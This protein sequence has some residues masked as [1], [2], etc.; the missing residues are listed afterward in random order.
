MSAKRQK[1]QWRNRIV[2]EGTQAAAQ[3]LAHPLNARRHPAAQ[4]DALRGVLSEVGWVQRVIVN[5]TTGH[6]LDG[7]ARIEEALS[8]D[9]SEPVPFVEVEVSEAEERLILA[10]LDPVS[11]MATYDKE[12]LDTLLREVSTGDAAVRE[13]LSNLAKDSGLY[14]EGERGEG[15][16][17]SFNFTIK[18]DDVNELVRLQKMLGV[19]SPSIRCDE[20]MRQMA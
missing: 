12:V 7:H 14:G 5:R 17:E 3:F 6:V 4:R 11:A 13:M 19:K 8:R 10:S 18:C 20:F 16:S 9:E 2:G 15:Y 1:E